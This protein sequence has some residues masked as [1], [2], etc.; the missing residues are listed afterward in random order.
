MTL[1]YFLLADLY[2]R[3]GAGGAGAGMGASRSAAAPADR[4]RLAAALDSWQRRRW[5]SQWRLPGLFAQALTLRTVAD[6]GLDLVQGFGSLDKSYITESTGSGAAFVDFDVDGNLDV[7]LVNAL[8]ESAGALIQVPAAHPA[9]HPALAAG[10]RGEGTPF[11][12]RRRAGVSRGADLRRS[13]RG[14]MGHRRYLG[15]RRQRRLARPVHLR[16]RHRPAVS[17]QR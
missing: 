17:Q 13:P 11:V 2:N 16:H 5:P 8:S 15:R 12:P 14:R 10:R 3:T 9:A 4:W 7:V 6:S 1:G